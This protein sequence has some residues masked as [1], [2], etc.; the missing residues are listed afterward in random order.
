MCTSFSGS[1][2]NWGISLYGQKCYFDCFSFC[3]GKAQVFHCRQQ[4]LIIWLINNG[5]INMLITNFLCSITQVF[6]LYT[7]ELMC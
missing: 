1:K 3:T 4:E 7:K 2:V 6:Q 5:V